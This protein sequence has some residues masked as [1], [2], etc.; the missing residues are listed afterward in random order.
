MCSRKPRYET[1]LQLLV[2]D[3]FLSQKTWTCGRER[4]GRRA[5]PAGAQL[6]EE[7]PL[8]PSLHQDEAPTLAAKVKRNISRAQAC[9]K[10]IPNGTAINCGWG[11]PHQ[12]PS[13]A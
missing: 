7:V 11:S 12:L 10:I 5:G 4:L 2:Y 8:S 6:A 1:Y 9:R 3:I 13:V